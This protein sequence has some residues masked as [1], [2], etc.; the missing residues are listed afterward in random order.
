MGELNRVSFSGGTTNSSGKVGGLIWESVVQQP[1]LNKS[2]ELNK[3][4]PARFPRMG[5]LP[6]IET[7]F[8]SFRTS[9]AG[10]IAD[11]G[12]ESI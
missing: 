10:N 4:L 5:S 3:V 12:I 8:L 2:R 11:A 7:M 1:R 9:G 6:R